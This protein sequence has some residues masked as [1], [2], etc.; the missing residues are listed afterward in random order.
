MNFDYDWK[1]EFY[2]SDDEGPEQAIYDMSF[3]DGEDCDEETE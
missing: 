1:I 2:D 3:A